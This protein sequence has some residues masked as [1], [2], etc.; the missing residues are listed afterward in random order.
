[1]PD[2][3]SSTKAD[4]AT[5]CDNLLSVWDHKVFE[6]AKYIAE[7]AVIEFKATIWVNKKKWDALGPEIQNIMTEEWKNVEYE[8]RGYAKAGNERWTQFTKSKGIKWTTLTQA[9]AG[10]MRQAVLDDVNDW[11]LKNCKKYGPA[12]V[13]MLKPYF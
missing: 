9:E 6:F 12:I 7:P 13:K 5:T 8:H 11:Y 3:L 4:V 1:V 2:S 10:K